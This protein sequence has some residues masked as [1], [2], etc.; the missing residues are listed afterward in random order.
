MTAETWLKT[1]EVAAITRETSEHT[2][3]RAKRGDF[4]GA[5]QL[6]R[7]WRIPQ[8]GLD[9][10]LTP[11]PAPDPAPQPAFR[12]PRQKRLATAT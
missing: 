9:A 1:S 5:V 8:S 6:G 10:F 3:R 2:S 7:N 11:P 4:P 12:S